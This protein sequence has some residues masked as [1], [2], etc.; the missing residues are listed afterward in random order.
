MIVAA[1]LMAVACSAFGSISE[2]MDHFVTDVE[3]ECENY[4]EKDWKLTQEEYEKLLTEFE[5]NYDSYTDEE[6]QEVAKAIGRYNGLVM[7]A[8]MK[9]L[10][11]QVEDLGR[12]AAPM[13][14]GFFEGLTEKED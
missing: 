7:R 14:D 4:E 5:E 11:N 12:K 13:I 9:S 3:K 6:K 2:R 8:G 1:A 10:F